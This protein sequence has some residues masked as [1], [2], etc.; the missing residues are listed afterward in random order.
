M[1]IPSEIVKYC[2]YCRRY[3]VHK[4]KT[5]SKGKTRTLSEGQRRFKRRVI[6]GYGAF[7]RPK[8][9][10]SSRYGVKISKKVNLLLVCT[11]CGK[12]HNWVLN[13]RAKKWEIVKK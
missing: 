8:Q 13:L 3:T 1:K 7:C 2:P 4:V 6:K 5:V 11:E 12:A 9:N 10:V